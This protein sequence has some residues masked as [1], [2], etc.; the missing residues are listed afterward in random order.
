MQN[1]KTLIECQHYTLNGRSITSNSY[2]CTVIMLVFMIM[3]ISE[4]L[5]CGATGGM[6]ILQKSV[7]LFS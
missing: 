1:F 5:K 4:L 2:V 6:P 7:S 3:W